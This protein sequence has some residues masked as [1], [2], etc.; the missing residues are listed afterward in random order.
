MN[1]WDPVTNLVVTLVGV[2]VV[3]L[4]LLALTGNIHCW[5]IP[6][7]GTGCNIH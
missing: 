3:L 2:A 6:I 5:T 7:I 1:S 4:L